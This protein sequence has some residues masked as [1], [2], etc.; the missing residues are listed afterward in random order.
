MYAFL[1]TIWPISVPSNQPCGGTEVDV[2]GLSGMSLL[3]WLSFS[4]HECP[5]TMDC[6]GH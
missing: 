2:S 4:G 5:D 1:E 3:E 6:N